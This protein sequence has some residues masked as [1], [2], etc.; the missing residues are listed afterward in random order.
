M[1]CSAN[2]YTL[3]NDHSDAKLATD[4]KLLLEQPTLSDAV[5]QVS[6]QEF[7]VSKNSNIFIIG[8]TL[9]R[10]YYCT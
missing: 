9:Q 7:N 1:G 3:R 6:D 5:L 10:I 4:F 2:R 8:P